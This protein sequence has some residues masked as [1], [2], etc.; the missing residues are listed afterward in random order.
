MSQ[1]NDE[2][3][4]TLEDEAEDRAGRLPALTLAQQEL[5]RRHMGLVG[6]HLRNRVPTPRRPRRQREYDDL[7][8]EGCVALARAAAR[9]NPERDGVFAAYALPRIRGAIFR[10]LHDGFTLV[11]IPARAAANFRKQSPGAGMSPPVHVLEINDELEKAMTVPHRDSRP[12]ETIRHAL[13]RR[14]ELAVRRTLEQMRQRTWR[15][16]NPTP[17]MA[18][19]AEERMLVNSERERTALRQIARDFN[20]SSGRASEYER[21]FVTAVRETLEADVQIRT[22]LEMA[23]E[24]ANG[25]DGIVDAERQTR[26]RQVEIAAFEERFLRMS[27]ADQAQAIYSLIERSSH[28]VPEIA[29]NLFCLTLSDTGETARTVA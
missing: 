7:F 22:L 16:R 9:W 4:F 14:Y 8:Q 1:I 20:I 11:R 23:A 2:K 29:R 24:D 10:A 3:D 6:V 18:R 12:N 27:Q 25:Q 17:I 19:I 26:L 15:Q 28:C 21:N 13:R 5:V